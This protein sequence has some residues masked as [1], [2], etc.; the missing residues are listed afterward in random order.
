MIKK[1][2]IIINLTGPKGNI[3]YILGLVK[4]LSKELNYDFNK[5]H[6]EVL[7]GNYTNAIKV[8]EKYFGE[9]IIFIK[10]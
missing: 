1:N 3:F 10:K 7:N 2:K 5:I 4:K 6:N 8:I 9:Y